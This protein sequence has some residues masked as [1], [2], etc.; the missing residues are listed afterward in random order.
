MESPLHDHEAREDV[1]FANG[2]DPFARTAYYH[3]VP[4]VI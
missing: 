4:E 3:L 2:L 1:I